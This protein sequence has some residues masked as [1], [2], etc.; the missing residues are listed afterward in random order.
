MYLTFSLKACHVWTLALALFVPGGS[1]SQHVFAQEIDGVKCIVDGDKN[2]N[3]EIFS[4]HL[5]GN[6]HFCCS[7]CK[8]KYD[9]KPDDYALKG[10][11]QITLDGQYVQ[12]ACPLGGGGFDPDITVLVGG[13]KIGVCCEGCQATLA[14]M[15]TEGRIKKV[16]DPATFT[17][18]FQKKPEPAPVPEP[19]PVPTPTPEPVPE[20]EPEPSS[21]VSH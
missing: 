9:A 17:T 14:A 10:N 13:V 5:E 8:A 16:F 15:D 20:P 21:I 4:K 2:A 11:H 18:H 12:T 1:L 3:R 6:V 19:E 7:G